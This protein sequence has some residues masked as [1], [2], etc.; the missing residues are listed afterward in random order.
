[1]DAI[2]REVSNFQ[3]E[4][5]SS[6]ALAATAIATVVLVASMKSALSDL[7][8]MTGWKVEP[9]KGNVCP[10]LCFG[11]FSVSVLPLTSLLFHTVKIT[12]KNHNYQLHQKSMA[13]TCFTPLALM[14]ITVLSL[15]GL[16]KYTEK[17]IVPLKGHPTANAFFGALSVSYFAGSVFAFEPLPRTLPKDM[18]EELRG[19]MRVLP[20][21]SLL[22]HPVKITLKNHNYQLQRKPLAKTCLTTLT[23]AALTAFSLKGLQKYTEKKIVPLK[24]H[25]TINAFFGALSVSYLAGSMF[26]FKPISRVLPEDMFEGLAGLSETFLNGEFEPLSSDK[27]ADMRTQL[28]EDACQIARSQE[29]FTMKLNLLLEIVDHAS[30]PSLIEEIEKLIDSEEFRQAYPANFSAILC[31]VAEKMA[32]HDLEKAKRAVDRTDDVWKPMAIEC[33][34]TEM[35]KMNLLDEAKDLARKTPDFDPSVWTEI[36]RLEAQGDLKKAL[37]TAMSFENPEYRAYALIGYAQ[38][39]PEYSLD[40]IDISGIPEP[41]LREVSMELVKVEAT[42]DVNQA[43]EKILNLGNELSQQCRTEWEAKAYIEIAKEDS[44]RGMPLALDKAE[45][46]EDPWTR[47]DVFIQMAEVDPEESLKKLKPLMSQIVANKNAHTL[48]PKIVEI[49]A[50]LSIYDAIKTTLFCSNALEDTTLYSRTTTTNRC[51]DTILIALAKKDPE[52][53]KRNVLSM[54]GPDRKVRLLSRLIEPPI[55]MNTK[56]AARR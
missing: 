25:P 13:K 29:N 14:I 17:K 23:L 4:V 32:M 9:F 18:A 45:E 50:R 55:A 5:R 46:I 35:I 16:Q 37:E 44:D 40:E 11:A 52:T 6:E 42:R 34:A 28:F 19:L 49:E 38:A 30:P 27:I 43:I 39:V 7:Q 33:I 47:A 3:I 12:L 53:A 41:S 8:R 36:V 54:R 21:T 56:S 1:M 26:A 10:S 2:R 15:K 48:I 22:F 20:L 51:V 31:T 24:G